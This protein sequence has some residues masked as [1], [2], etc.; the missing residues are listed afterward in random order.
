MKRMCD[1]MRKK[2]PN[3]SESG[4]V[5]SQVSFLE[6]RHGAQWVSVGLSFTLAMMLLFMFNFYNTWVFVVA[7]D[8]VGVHHLFKVISKLKIF[9]GSLNTKNTHLQEMCHLTNSST[10]YHSS[11]IPI[12]FKNPFIFFQTCRLFFNHKNDFLS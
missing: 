10:L 3:R 8:L 4:L 2:R 6:R 11:T 9:G 12:I 5:Y 1:S 7:C